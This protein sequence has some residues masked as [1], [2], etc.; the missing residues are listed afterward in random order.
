MDYKEKNV[1]KINI[2]KSF[3]TSI[4]TAGIGKPQFVIC[5]KFYQLNR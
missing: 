1:K 5:L 3:F 4:I 2:M